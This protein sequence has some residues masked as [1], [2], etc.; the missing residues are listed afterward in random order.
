MTP[1]VAALIGCATE[2]PDA[3]TVE[4]GSV[5]IALAT[6]API[7][8]YAGADTLV[9]R[10]LDRQ[11]NV[12]AEG[13]GD[14]ETGV[15]MPDLDTFGVVNVEITARVED[16]VLSAGRTG[17]LL[18]ADGDDRAITVLFL[19][20]NEAIELDHTP[21]ADRVE[22]VSFRASDGRVVLL[23]GRR[24]SSTEVWSTS[25]WWDPIN[26]F[27]DTGPALPGPVYNASVTTLT[28]RRILVS[29]GWPSG[30]ADTP[31]A[32]TWVLSHDG[33]TF[34]ALDDM[35]IGRA[36]HCLAT[37]QDD[38]VVA[39]GG[40]GIDGYTG[41]DVLRPSGDDFNWTSLL[42]DDLVTEDVGGCVGTGSGYVVTTGRTTEAWG[43]MDVREASNE[44]IRESFQEM[45]GVPRPLEGA[46][47]VPL[48]GD[49]VWVLGGW[50]GLS[51]RDEGWLVYAQV[52]R[53]ESSVGLAS[54]RAWG[55]WRWWEE[56]RI[57]AVAGGYTS[58]DRATAN[59]TV[60]L[61]DLESGPLLVVDAPNKE[62]RL[63]VID[64]GNLLLTG[65]T[66]NGEPAGAWVI[67][68]WLE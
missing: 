5:S 26:G 44:Q 4:V 40:S 67:V 28:D 66:A 65:G 56:G 61:V 47:L 52:A 25:E 6:P 60:E 41:V 42:M 12:I 17:D 46:L 20:V 57:V 22:H 38:S 31:S 49:E 11:G 1:L 35:T 48:D 51:P 43:V 23:G 37:F 32:D 18:V 9:V 54:A 24:P 21:I 53:A 19:P 55:S 50:D 39:L 29:G 36:D 68:P 33:T 58:G 34:T 15:S 13:E 8:P 64:G 30:A 7:D 59:A 2:A 63:E 14:P 62:P 27:Q 45:S 16:T 10:V 3:P